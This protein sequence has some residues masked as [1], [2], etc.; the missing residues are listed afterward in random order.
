MSTFRILIEIVQLKFKPGRTCRN[1]VT[2]EIC[3]WDSETYNESTLK[4]IHSDLCNI[5]KHPTYFPFTRLRCQ[6]KTLDK[7]NSLGE[8]FGKARPTIPENSLT[9][10]KSKNISKILFVQLY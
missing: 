1:S 4:F 8:A 3:K 7:T 2:A 9:V 5:D 6:K 10:E